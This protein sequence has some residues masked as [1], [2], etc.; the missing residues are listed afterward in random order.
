LQYCDPRYSRTVNPAPST[1]RERAKLRRRRAIQLAA[2]RLFTERGYEGTTLSDIA[3]AAEVSPRTVSLYFPS[4]TD[5]ALS[6]SNEV[7]VRLSSIFRQLPDAGFLEVIDRWLSQETEF[8]DT[9]L[10][11][12]ANAMFVVN[13]ELRALSSAPINEAMRIGGDALFAELGLARNDPMASVVAASIAAAI[14][15]YQAVS[16]VRGASP[17]LLPALLSYLRGLIESA[18]AFQR[19]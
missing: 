13:P 18:V 17:Q 12:L 2:L 10:A 16:A 7:A 9:E 19:L 6:G 15:E 1:L 3:E 8:D 14:F 5:L 4:K 11:V